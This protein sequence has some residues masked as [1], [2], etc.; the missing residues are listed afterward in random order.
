MQFLQV[1][2]VTQRLTHLSDDELDRAAQVVR[3]QTEQ[4]SA[5][6][7]STMG[8]LVHWLCASQRKTSKQRLHAHHEFWTWEARGDTTHY[9]N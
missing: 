1:E 4:M 6:R 7:H 2:T 3:R 5:H 9:V 8:K